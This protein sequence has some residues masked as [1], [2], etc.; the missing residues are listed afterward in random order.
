MNILIADPVEQTCVDIL[1]AEGFEVDVRT[2]LRE[3]QILS[4]IGKYEALIVRSSTRVT[5][6]IISAGKL[7]RV[8]GRAG[9][10]VD[11]IDLET[12][13]RRGV[14]VMN[15]PGGNTIS[16]AEHTM[17]LILALARNIPQAHASLQKGMWDRKSFVGTEL[18]GKTIGI[19][20][21]GKV[22]REVSRRC[23][24]FDMTVIGYDPVLTREAAGRI[25]VALVDLDELLQRS[26]FVTVHTPLNDETRNLISART[27]RLCKPGVR[28][29]NCARGGIVD[30]R[31]LLEALD[32]GR[33]AGAALDV[34]EQEPPSQNPLFQHPHVVVTPHLGASTEEAQE[35]IAIQIAHQIADVLT[36][37]SVVGSVNGDMMQLAMNKEL[38]PYLTLGEKLGKLTAQLMEGKLREMTVST[39]GALL[40]NTGTAISA[41]VLKGL[42]ETLLSEPVNY[43]NA[44]AIAKERGIGVVETREQVHSSYSQLVKVRFET[45][46]EKRV[47]SGTVFGQDN[48]RITGI[49]AF[50]FELNPEGYLLLYTNVDK[51][52]MLATVGSILAEGKIN[53]A[54]VA[55][56][57]RGR[58]E[59][60]LTAMVLD[61]VV[62]PKTLNRL[63]GVEGISEVKMITL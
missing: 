9:A 12:A 51:P 21:L 28:V 53:I 20:G 13:T 22:G 14:I 38:R 59:R 24:G 26:D 33:V 29:I 10:G 11:N 54:G 43:I 23:A 16:T 62:P 31:A 39:S 57:R 47:L 8:I 56:G 15:T 60:A 2:G 49:D 44:T 19:V 35:K 41:S 34:F 42:F 30:E 63:S 6:G 3:D 17:S 55:L 4:I 37:R 40:E 5:A 52:G 61:E 32:E 50:H 48:V 46:K 27:L 58:G 7:L 18:A 45:D 1:K 25:G 36:G